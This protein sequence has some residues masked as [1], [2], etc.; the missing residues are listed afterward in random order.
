MKFFKRTTTI[1]FVFFCSIF[2]EFYYN[3]N[4]FAAHHVSSISFD[5]IKAEEELIL[6]PVFRIKNAHNILNFTVKINYDSSKLTYKSFFNS[7]IKNKDELKLFRRGNVITVKYLSQHKDFFAQTLGNFFLFDLKFI[8][9]ENLEHAEVTTE[10]KEIKYYDSENKLIIFNEK[11]ENNSKINS[12]LSTKNTDKTFKKNKSKT[13]KN[14][15]E[16]YAGITDTENDVLQKKFTKKTKS[17]ERTKSEYFPKSLTANK[18]DKQLVDKT[19][20]GKKT[21]LFKNQ[22]D[23][24]NFKTNKIRKVKKPRESK[25]NCVT[26]SVKELEPDGLERINGGVTKN[27]KMSP[28]KELRPDSSR[29]TNSRKIK[30]RKIAT[31]EKPELYDSEITD[32]EITKS[33]MKELRPDSSK[34]RKIKNIKIATM[35]KPELY[36]SEIT[37]TKNEKMSPIKRLKLDNS[38]GTN[39]KMLENKKISNEKCLKFKKNMHENKQK[40]NKRSSNNNKNNV[41]KRDKF[42]SNKNTSEPSK[43]PRKNIKSTKPNKKI[44][45][46]KTLK[47]HKGRGKSSKT[48]SKKHKTKRN[49]TLNKSEKHEKPQKKNTSSKNEHK[50]LNDEEDIAKKSPV[51]ENN[52][53]KTPLIVIAAVIALTSLVYLFLR[54]KIL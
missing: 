2:V 48:K 6:R 49:S 33:P 25:F 10:I 19:I 22:T 30:N 45:N 43:A 23:L 44:S 28:I 11:D 32:S 24:E 31:M 42:K 13:Q 15:K 4:V 9:K 35:E 7:G 54:A 51:V 16:S 18:K 53:F 38:K 8:C 41:A 46:G 26:N 17:R 1:L 40:S 37:I 52:V 3:I 29:S 20:E 5:Q 12:Q 27:E 36:D 50:N 21:K 34:S 14:C 39:S 47:T